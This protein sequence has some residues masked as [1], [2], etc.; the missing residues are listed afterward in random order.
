MPSLKYE[1]VVEQIRSRKFAPVYLLWGE[2]D[3]FIDRIVELF[4]T[5]VLDD[6]QKEFDFSVTYGLDLKG[7]EPGLKGLMAHCKQFPVMSPL[8]LV[9]IK[10]AQTIDRWEALENYLQKP[11]ETTVLVICFK[12]KKPDKRKSFYK[13]IEKT[14]V[15]YESAPIKEKDLNGW[16]SRYLQDAGYSVSPEAL[17][18]LSETMGTNLNLI[19]N[20]LEK[21][22]INL[23]KG[24]LITEDHIETYIGI[25]KEYNVFTL[26]KAV[27][28][29]NAA[30]TRKICTY[31]RQNPKDFPPPLILIQFYR[32][33]SK[34]VQIHAFLRSGTPRTEWAARLGINPYFIRQYETAASLYSYRD[35][36]HILNIIKQYDLKS[37]GVDANMDPEA[38]IDEFITRVLYAC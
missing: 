35:T 32:L 30:E 2:E 21:L 25:N 26:E 34:V 12:H 36:A 6:M 31:V 10:E 23:P 19:T 27:S 17:M 22:F 13:L 24:S 7:K 38:W 11:V 33:F 4:E 28:A 15:S 3:Y 29:R 37:K 20:E 18:L 5:R 16:V 14:G 9:I 8:Q 1:Q